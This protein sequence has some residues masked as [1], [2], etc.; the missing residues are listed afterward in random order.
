MFLSPGITLGGLAVAQ[1][2][3]LWDRRRLTIPDHL[4]V[5]FGDHLGHVGHGAVGHLDRVAIEDGSQWMIR[6]EASLNDLQEGGGHVGPDPLV[7]WWIKRWNPRRS[8]TIKGQHCDS[9][10]NIHFSVS[11]FYA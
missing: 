8:R 10:I 9:L 1:V 2:T 11:M 7:E 4:V 3:W 5:V 6:W